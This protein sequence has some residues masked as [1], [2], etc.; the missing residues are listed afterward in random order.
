[1]PK[2]IG[3]KIIYSREEAENLGLRMPSPEEIARSQAILDQFDKDRAA[4]GPAPEGTAPGFGGRFSN[5]LAGTEYEGWTLD[6]KTGQWRD[7]HG[8]PVD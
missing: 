7:Q 6:P 2:N 4:A 3:G 1:M 5:D 8:N